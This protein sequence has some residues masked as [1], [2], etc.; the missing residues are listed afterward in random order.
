MPGYLARV[1]RDALDGKQAFDHAISVMSC[2][3]LLLDA[4]RKLYARIRAALRP[5]GKYIEGDSIV[6]ADME[7]QFLAEYHQDAAPVPPAPDGYYRIDVPYS[8]ETQRSLLLEAGF[9]DFELL[10]QIINASG[11]NLAV[12]VVT[13]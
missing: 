9:S 4:N 10:W 13:A 5:G 6:P 2:H 8:L 1:G 7:R 11:W 3:H 12:F